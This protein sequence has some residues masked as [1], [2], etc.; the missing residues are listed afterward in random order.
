M[1][2]LSTISTA[3]RPTGGYTTE[4][5]SAAVTAVKEPKTSS[6]ESSTVMLSEAAKDQY[7]SNKNEPVN[8]EKE[9]GPNQQAGQEVAEKGSDREGSS[10]T[11]AIAEILERLQELLKE[12]QQ[13]LRV[14]QQQMTLAMAEMKSAGN[15]SQKMVAMLK[16]QAEQ[17]LVISAQGEVLEIHAQI[18]KI[19][20]EQQKQA[21][22]GRNRG[23]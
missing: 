16:V 10:K 14:A 11:D 19:L 2:T 8:N 3:M 23:E 5:M 22:S 18:N 7:V 1:Q 20:Q 6:S 13:R 12:A 15:E 9:D 17:T 4:I 21:K